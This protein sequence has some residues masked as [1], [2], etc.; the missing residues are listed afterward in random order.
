MGRY[1]NAST[2]AKIGPVN[3]IE[4]DERWIDHVSNLNL[5]NVTFTHI[6]A[7]KVDYGSFPKGTP[8]IANIPYQIT[9][10]LIE[11]FTKYNH[12]LGPITIMIQKEMAERLVANPG[13]KRYGAMTL[14]CH[15]YFN[16]NKGFG[17]SRNCFTPPPNVDSQVIQLTA[18]P[19]LLSPEDEPLFFAMT[20]TLFWGRRKTIIKCLK[21]GPYLSLQDGYP[22]QPEFKQRGESLN[23]KETIHLFHHIKPYLNHKKSSTIK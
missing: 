14:F 5:E 21:T 1:F 4:I 15:Y 6:D 13:S 12:H 18:A 2:H 17:V 11:Q 19:S 9:S 23:L 22:D 3:V 20:R 8:I 7:L 10:P 16:L